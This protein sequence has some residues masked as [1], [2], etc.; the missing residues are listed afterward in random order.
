MKPTPVHKKGE[1]DKKLIE[2]YLTEQAAQKRATEAQQKQEREDIATGRQRQSDYYHQRNSPADL[3]LAQE[4]A[5]F[6]KQDTNKP[7][8]NYGVILAFIL[9]PI[10]FFLVFR[11][12]PLFEN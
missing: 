11:I 6:E 7:Q 10:V 5:D 1:L 3:K 8:K 12:I 4:Q 9:A 2:R